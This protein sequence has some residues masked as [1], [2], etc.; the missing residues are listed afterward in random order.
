M[1]KEIEL[2]DEV[3]EFAMDKMEIEKEEYDVEVL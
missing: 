3:L 2:Y 1:E